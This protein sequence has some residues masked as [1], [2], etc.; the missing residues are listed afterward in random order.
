MAAT[1]CFIALAPGA[2]VTPA[3]IFERHAMMWPGAPPL[4][5]LETGDNVAKFKIGTAIGFI[6][7]MNMRIP[8]GD[9]E[10]PC[11]ASFIWPTASQD[12]LAHDSHFVASVT[13]CGARLAAATA[14]TRLVAAILAAC[15]GAIGVYA[16]G[17]PD[18]WLPLSYI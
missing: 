11:K 10:E 18:W 15:P 3:E 6:V 4:T 13:E 8:P 16:M 14:L 12:L 9:L 1:V 5:D 17:M 2:H 7:K